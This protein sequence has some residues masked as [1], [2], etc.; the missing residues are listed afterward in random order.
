MRLLN[1]S[2][3]Q[4]HEFFGSKIPFYA[5]LSHRWEESE[6]SFKDVTKSRNLD[7]PGWA[8]VRASCALAKSRGKQWIWIDTCCIDRRSSAELSEAINSMFAW[9]KNSIECY[10]YL[11]DVLAEAGSEA[12]KKAFRSSEWFL[13]GWTLQ[14]LI[15]P[16][17]VLFFNQAWTMIGTRYSLGQEISSITGIEADTWDPWKW[18]ISY[19]SIARRMSWASRRVCTREEDM[20]YCL[21]GIFEINMPLLYGEGGSRAFRRLQLEILKTSDDESIFAWYSVR[22]LSSDERSIFIRYQ[23]GD[24]SVEDEPELS[25]IIHREK[26]PPTNLE[27]LAPSPAYFFKS[28]SINYSKYAQRLP[29]TVTNKGLQFSADKRLL[30]GSV[31]KTWSSEFRLTITYRFKITCYE[32]PLNCFDSKTSHCFCLHI[33]DFDDF[34]LDGFSLRFSRLHPDTLEN[35]SEEVVFC[36]PSVLKVQ[37]EFFEVPEMQTLYLNI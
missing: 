8:K 23:Y 1:T 5:I 15:A 14:E 26:L 10:A 12:F 32:V 17:D 22:P 18:R 34:E 19:L 25:D 21:L 29:Y 30:A 36:R 33:S 37:S 24:P 9:Y 20:A 4:L 3:I 7:A 28:H 6:I 31:Y 2:T 11:V 13:R 27:L 35:P 16:K